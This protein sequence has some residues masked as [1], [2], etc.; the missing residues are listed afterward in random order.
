MLHVW[1]CAGA[2]GDLRTHGNEAALALAA[3]GSPRTKLLL[4][5]Y[6][7]HH[8][9]YAPPATTAPPHPIM[10]LLTLRVVV[11]VAE[12]GS[13]SAGSTRVHLAVGAA[14]ARISALEASS[15]VR[16]F[17][18]SSRGV[19]L[20]PAG[21]MLVQR[22]RELLADAD[23]LS[24]DLRD[25]SLGLQGHVRILANTSAILEILPA[26][27]Q[28]LARSHPL[29]KVDVEER[30]SPGI[31]LA[32]LEGRADLGI[33]DIAHPLLGLTFRDLMTDTLVLVVPRGHRLAERASVSLNDTLDEDYVCPG[34]GTALTTR[35]VAAASLIG[36]P[37]KIRMQMRSFDAVCRMVAGELG[38]S[39]LPVEAI[40]PQLAH[41][42]ILAVPLSD[43]WARRTHR[44]ALREGVAP[45]AAVRSIVDALL[46]A[47]A[48]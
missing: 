35:L 31:P 2:G 25:C 20:T 10:D 5:P 22:A 7:C 17:E 6:A 3:A 44:L 1:I 19:Q 28:A 18:R 39:V 37:V 47:K 13:I 8:R 9:P 4:G 21:H 46:Q 30:P 40:T 36:L 32:L 24:V 48:G 11:A 34:D 29:I 41:L 43:S 23:R 16:F 26:R 38:V 15:G 42:P 14:S 12:S 33:V 45:S 27:L